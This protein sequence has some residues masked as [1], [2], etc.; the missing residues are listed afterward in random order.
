MAG[1][2]AAHRLSLLQSILIIAEHLKNDFHIIAPDMRGY[3]DTEHVPTGYWLPD[4]IADIDALL[5]HF[6]LNDNVNLL[7]HSKGGIISLMY[8]G[9]A[10]TRINK[11]MSLD[12]LTFYTPNAD[13]TAQ[14]YRQWLGEVKNG[15]DPKVYNNLD[16]FKQSVS[17]NNPS[18]SDEMITYLATI[19]SRPLSSDANGK[20]E[21]KHDRKHLN[22]ITLRHQDHEYKNLWK[23]VNATVGIT[24]AENSRLHKYYQLNGDLEQAKDLLNIKEENN[25]LVKDSYHLLHIEQP[26]AT[27]KCIQDFF[28]D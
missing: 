4:Y 12:G 11:L 1:W 28:N 26:K 7:G 15:T 22:T 23:E 2:I 5:D 13:K 3:G 21:I 25:Y 24:M 18:L 14:N 27:A 9:I 10:N 17:R 6:E 16:H 8:A 19:W 20:V